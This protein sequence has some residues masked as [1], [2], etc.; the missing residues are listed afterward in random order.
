[1]TQKR[2]TPIAHCTHKLFYFIEKK[3][4]AQTNSIFFFIDELKFDLYKKK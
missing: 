2:A 3:K 1:M 4:K